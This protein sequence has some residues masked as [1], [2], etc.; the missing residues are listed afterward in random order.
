MLIRP[1]FGGGIKCIKSSAGKFNNM[2]TRKKQGSHSRSVQL[3]LSFSDQYRLSWMLNS[4]MHLH[5]NLDHETT[6]TIWTD[7]L[8][9]SLSQFAIS[10][11]WRVSKPVEDFCVC[12][13]FVLRLNAW[14][15][16]RKT[17]HLLIRWLLAKETSWMMRMTQC[18]CLGDQEKGIDSND[19]MRK[20]VSYK[21]GQNQKRICF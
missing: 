19:S 13:L 14:G 8:I 2:R 15:M 21:P 3:V 12:F 5:A 18:P 9:L 6:T 17:C 10:R 4:N 11:D 7:K 20:T 16:R 1:Y